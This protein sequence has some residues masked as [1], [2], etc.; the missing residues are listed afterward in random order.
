MATN[1]KYL[2]ENNLLEA[3]KH[4]MRL[5]EAYIP[6]VLPEEEIEEAGED[7]QDPNAMG[8]DPNAMGGMPA[9]G[10]MPQGPNAMGGGD[11]NAM[12]GQDP[13]AGGA[14]PNA[15]GGDPMASD[16][17]A[18]PN[19]Q[20]PMADTMGGDMGADPMEDTMG[21]EPADDGETIDIDGLTQ[22]EDKLNVKQNR[23]GRDLS[24]VDNRITTLI[25]TI[26]N[27]LT[28][29]DSNNSEIESLKAEFEKRNPTQTEKLNLRS[30]DSYPF[31]VKPNEYWAEKAK[32]GGYEAYSDN[33]EPTTKEYV[34]TN[35]DVDNPSDDIAN[36]FFKIDDDD[37][38]TLEKMFNI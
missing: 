36:T 11:P 19:A 22:A 23:I 14:D 13:M 32:E 8:G 6:T 7:M 12:G 9:D 33:D 21:E 2:K 4:F 35:D 26:N 31:N 29:V 18:D 17:G 38:Q 3:H 20:D 16:M 30:L 5:S 37:I 34:I 25:D 28:K 10:G 24:K 1:I 27:L 15:M